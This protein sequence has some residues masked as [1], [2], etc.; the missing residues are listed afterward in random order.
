M[1][2]DV[3][4]IMD[5]TLTLIYIDEVRVKKEKTLTKKMQHEKRKRNDYS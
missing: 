1:T 2:R 5:K 4:R 3:Q